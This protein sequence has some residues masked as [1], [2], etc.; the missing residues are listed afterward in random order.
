MP[1]SRKQF[2][3]VEIGTTNISLL[4]AREQ[5]SGS[6]GTL[7]IKCSEGLYVMV[8]WFYLKVPPFGC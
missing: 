1:M 6:G 7:F 4:G 3:I 8:R 2:C 5:G